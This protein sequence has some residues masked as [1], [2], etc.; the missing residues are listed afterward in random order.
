MEKMNT[1]FPKYVVSFKEVNLILTG[2]IPEKPYAQSD[3]DLYSRMC[4]LKK[5]DIDFGEQGR[6]WT[7]KAR[8]K[9][10]VSTKSVKMKSEGGGKRLKIRSLS[11]V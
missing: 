9:L 11:K 5:C 3:L 10:S 7:E 8:T 1:V 2:K 6:G 4:R